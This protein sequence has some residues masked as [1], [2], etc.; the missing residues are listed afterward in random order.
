MKKIVIP[1]VALLLA[2]VLFISFPLYKRY[3]VGGF[4]R[5]FNNIHMLSSSQLDPYYVR[6][7][8]NQGAFALTSGNLH[9]CSAALTREGQ[10]VF[11]FLRPDLSE[12]PC[13]RL[14]FPDGCQIT[15]AD[16][17][18]NEQGRDKTWIVCT[19]QGK[20]RTFS[21]TGLGVY[22]RIYTCVSPDGFGEMGANE[23]LAP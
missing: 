19:Y 2:G 14:T 13:V 8:S 6:A 7:E 17:G 15:V 18:K 9:Y 1:V 16:A 11:H 3:R 12:L 21:V 20:T 22:A 10:M 5:E 23:P 4:V